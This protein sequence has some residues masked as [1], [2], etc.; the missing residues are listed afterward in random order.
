MA[1]A[2]ALLGGALIAGCI[3]PSYEESPPATLSARWSQSFGGIMDEEAAVIAVDPSG[4]PIIGGYFESYMTFGGAYF[5]PV[6]GRDAFLAKYDTAGSHLWSLHFG[7]AG[8]E[9]VASVAV[10]RDGNALVAGQFTGSIMIK[11]MLFSAGPGIFLAKVDPAGAVLWSTAFSADAVS[12]ARAGGV[13]ADAEGNVLVTGTFGGSLDVRG[14]PLTSGATGNNAFIVKLDPTG[15]VLWIHNIED[16][17]YAGGEAIAADDAG[18]VIVTGSYLGAPTFG[19]QALPDGPGERLFVTKLGPAGA[20]LWSLGFASNEAEIQRGTA[21]AVDADQNIVV[22]GLNT[23]SVNLGGDAIAATDS[24]DSFA[25]MLGPAG[26]H[27]WSRGLDVTTKDYVRSAAVD[28]AGD[29]ILSGTANREILLGPDDDIFVANLDGASGVI[30]SLTVFGDERRQR[31]GGARLSPEGDLLLAG[32]FESELDLGA[33]ALM[34][35]GR[36]DVFVARL[37]PP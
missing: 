20:F 34:E 18:N 14:N 32:S 6:D 15:Q 26:N 31:A 10:D 12:A 8:A 1:P 16:A 5:T 13:A 30:A 27:L 35:H 37:V 19:V 24:L 21:L 3:L 2:A 9:D 23:G 11:E 33:G 28:G 25:L 4:N 29:V 7:T 36:L 22:A 17:E